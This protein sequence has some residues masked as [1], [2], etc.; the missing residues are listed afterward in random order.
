MMS[1]VISEKLAEL[2]DQMAIMRPIVEDA[3][4][5]LAKDVPEITNNGEVIVRGGSR[6]T[7]YSVFHRVT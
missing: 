5:E 6:K 4:S 1:G 3:K 2:D 7:A